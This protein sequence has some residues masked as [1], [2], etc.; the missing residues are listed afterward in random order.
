MIEKETKR[1]GDMINSRKLFDD[2]EKAHP[3][4]EDEMCCGILQNISDV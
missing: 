2:S 4:T 3:V 1:T